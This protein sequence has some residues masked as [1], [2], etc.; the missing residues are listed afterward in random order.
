MYGLILRET[1]RKLKRSVTNTLTFPLELARSVLTETDVS[2]WRRNRSVQSHRAKI[3]ETDRCWSGVSVKEQKK[4]GR[5][6]VTQEDWGHTW[7]LSI[8]I[9]WHLLSWRRGDSGS[10]EPHHCH[11]H[12]LPIMPFNRMVMQSCSGPWEA[13]R[14]LSGQQGRSWRMGRQYRGEDKGF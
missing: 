3:C 12:L 9:H 13:K 1:Y 5:E 8:F 14:P 6:C 10:C 2:E 11:F 4:R 7:G